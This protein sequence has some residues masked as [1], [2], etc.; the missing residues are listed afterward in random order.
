M[1]PSPICEIVREL[2]KKA[3]SR[4]RKGARIFTGAFYR[5]ARL[6]CGRRCRRKLGE[7]AAY[8]DTRRQR[9]VPERLVEP[10]HRHVRS[11]RVRDQAAVAALGRPRDLRL[12]QGSSDAAT[13]MRAGDRGQLVLEHVVGE[14]IELRPADD[15]V[16]LECNE[17]RSRL[18]EALP[19]ALGICSEGRGVRHVVDALLV[20]RKRTVRQFLRELLHADARRRRRPR[21]VAVQ[22][23]DV[24]DFAVELLEPATCGPADAGLGKRAD[25]GRRAQR[26]GMCQRGL[27]ETGADPAPAVLRKN[28]DHPEG[29]LRS[30]GAAC[31][32]GPDRAPFELGEEVAATVVSVRDPL[33]HLGA[34][35]RCLGEDGRPDLGVRVQVGAGLCSADHPERLSLPCCF[36]YRSPRWN[37]QTPSGTE[38]MPI[39]MSGQM[40]PQSSPTPAPSRIAARMPRSAYVAGE[41]VAIH[42]IHWGRTETG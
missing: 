37:T 21:L 25:E 27:K 38:T 36:A 1:T 17:D 14:S 16:A 9:S 19:P 28:A 41:I 18:G 42:C 7:R 6:L 40:S 35:H 34:G 2:Q 22:V 26:A 24:R 4:T 3:K 5:G 32:A 33:T 31:E 39:T 8:R 13:A 15:L 10:L 30:L 20:D 11:V 23:A 29:A 12:L